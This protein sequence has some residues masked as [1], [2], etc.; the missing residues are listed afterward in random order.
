MNR[1]IPINRIILTASLLGI[2]LAACNDYLDVKPED[3]F[4]EPQVYST[5]EGLNNALNG[6]YLNLANKNSYGRNLTMGT[7]EFMAQLYY[8]SEQHSQDLIRTYAYKDK[9]NKA[10]FEQIWKTAYASVLNINVFLQNMAISDVISTDKK[11]TLEGEALGLR[12]FYHFDMLRLFGPV[13]S[14][15]PDAIA[16]PYYTKA[17]TEMQELYKASVVIDLVLQDIERAEVLLENDPVI[18]EGFSANMTG[19][20]DFYKERKYRLNFYALKA[21][22]ARVLLYKGDKE[23]ALDCAKEVISEAQSLIRWV[24][25]SAVNDLANPDRIFYNEILF[26]FSNSKMYEIQDA[27]F[28]ENVNDASIYAPLPERLEALFEYNLEKDYRAVK[29]WMYP[30]AGKK[31]Y[32]TFFKYSDITNSNLERRFYQPLIRWSEMYLIAAECATDDYA[33]INYLNTLRANRGLN[34]LSITTDVELA[35][36]KEYMKEFYGEGQLFF[37]YKRM[38]EAILPDGGSTKDIIMSEEKYVVPLPDSEI[39]FRN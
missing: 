35:I 26:G 30:Y 21:L 1:L 23:A 8:T 32:R 39:R 13:F 15:N 25:V 19:E 24:E 27:V 4:L 38:N 37:Y 17:T 22:K 7:V 6:I 20:N 36:K 16:I 5:E 34:N 31:S 3:K 11:N 33:A 29:T 9:T 10:V 28:D 18:T 12:A 2:L 14:E